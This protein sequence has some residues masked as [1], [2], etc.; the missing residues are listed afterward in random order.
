M[1][2]IVPSST[3]TVPTPS[4]KVPSSRVPTPT[5]TSTRKYTRD[6]AG[7]Y[8]CPHCDVREVHQNTM[9]Y[10]IKGVHDKDFAFECTHCLDKP[11]FLQRCSWLQHLAT[12]H[13]KDPHPSDT[14]RNPYADVKYDCPACTHDT[15]TKA[16]LLIHFARTHCKEWIPAFEKT[17]KICTGCKKQCN[18]S[19]AYLHHAVKCFLPKAPLDHVNMISRIK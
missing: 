3:S 9:Y 11:K 8:V 1:P 5:L 2:S 4:S 10:H 12:K 14:E 13:P 17:T 18:S 6:D 16:N 15:H 7:L 19:T